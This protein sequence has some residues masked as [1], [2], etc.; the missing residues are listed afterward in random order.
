MNGDLNMENNE[1]YKEPNFF[2]PNCKISVKT[3]EKDTSVSIKGDNLSVLFGMYQL[4]RAYAEKRDMEVVDVLDILDGMDVSMKE[5]ETF[6]E[7]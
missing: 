2:S 4:I 1:T 5:G 6:Y 3:D 7:A